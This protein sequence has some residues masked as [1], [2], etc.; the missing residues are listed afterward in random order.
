MGLP[1]RA[2]EAVATA[3]VGGRHGGGTHDS[4]SACEPAAGIETVVDAAA[5]VVVARVLLERVRERVREADGLGRSVGGRRLEVVHDRLAPHAVGVVPAFQLH[6]VADRVDRLV[7]DLCVQREVVLRHDLHAVEHAPDGVVLHEVGRAVVRN[8]GIGSGARSRHIRERG[9]GRVNRRERQAAVALRATVVVVVVERVLVAEVAQL[10]L[11]VV[12]AGLAPA[13]VNALQL[14]ADDVRAVGNGHARQRDSGGHG[15][16]VVRVAQAVD[17]VHGDAALRHR[18]SFS[19]EAAE[20]VRNRAVDHAVHGVEADLGFLQSRVHE[21]VFV[22]SGV[23]REQQRAE[24]LVLDRSELVLGDSAAAH[25]R[26]AELGLREV[27]ACFAAVAC[28]AGEGSRTQTHA[29]AAGLRARR[30]GH[31]VRDGT[32]EGAGGVVAARDRLPERPVP[33][34]NVH[35]LDRPG[36]GLEIIKPARCRTIAPRAPLTQGAVR[37]RGVRGMGF[38]LV[39]EEG[40]FDAINCFE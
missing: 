26:V 22:P 31:P 39:L 40:F 28:L 32:I 25:V 27:G 34:E 20:R 12:R 11:L 4:A 33:A 35:T 15:H 38:I 7:D 1:V 5:E 17:A 16:V 9:D 24:K 8:L 30:P 14:A 3:A 10:Q 2:R 18:P 6:A 37:K 13:V 29:A 19:S 21:R 23:E 36:G